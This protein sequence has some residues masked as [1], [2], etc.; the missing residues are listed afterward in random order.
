MKYQKLIF[1]TTVAWKDK[2][3][4]TLIAPTTSTRIEVGT[5][6]EFPGGEEGRWSPESLFLGAISSCFMTTFLALAKR[7]DLPFSGF[8]CHASGVVES[9]QGKLAFTRVDLYPEL[10]LRDNSD[11]GLGE[12]II[13]RTE[14]YCLVSQSVKAT[15]QVHPKVVSEESLA[16]A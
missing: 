7:K 11:K 1:E 10:I 13:A 9:E 6:V 14:K 2:T 16:A 15:I 12:E 8:K 3:F 5:P 4:G